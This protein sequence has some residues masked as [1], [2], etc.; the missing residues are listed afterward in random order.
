MKSNNSC[1]KSFPGCVEVM[2]VGLTMV[3]TVGIMFAFDIMQ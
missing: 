2:I 1:P 3:I